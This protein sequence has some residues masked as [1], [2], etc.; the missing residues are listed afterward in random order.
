MR[1]T[2]KKPAS[3]PA[4]PSQA[5][6][7]NS[8]TAKSAKTSTR[9]KT[10]TKVKAPPSQA[11]DLVD[12]LIIAIRQNPDQMLHKLVE[13]I[14]KDHP[15]LFNPLAEKLTKDPVS[16]LSG[17][18]NS[19]GIG[20]IKTYPMQT[21]VP[22]PTTLEIEVNRIRGVDDEDTMISNLEDLFAY[23]FSNKQ[24]FKENDNLRRMH[25]HFLAKHN[26]RIFRAALSEVR[27]IPIIH[28]YEVALD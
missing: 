12:H 5:S 7:S 1:T 14:K 21:S 15:D 24:F 17:I 27:K 8:K 9:T 18:Q 19:F 10:K 28:E 2:K 6:N 16:L 23:A 25:Y 26:L 13:R 4:K 22:V 3:R 11:P 20:P